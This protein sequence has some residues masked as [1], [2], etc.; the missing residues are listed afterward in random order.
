ML[1]S[2]SELFGLGSARLASFVLSSG[3]ARLGLELSSSRA[4]SESNSSDSRSSS[5]F[6]SPIQNA[7]INA[8][9]KGAD[10]GYLGLEYLHK[11]LLVLHRTP[12]DSEPEW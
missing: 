5:F 6:D 10:E 2:L 1:P 11:P 7:I 3:S 8:L 4:F 12:A 9:K